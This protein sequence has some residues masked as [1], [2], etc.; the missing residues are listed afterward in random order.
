MAVNLELAHIDTSHLLEVVTGP[1]TGTTPT[2]TTLLVSV[3]VPVF[4]E[5]DVIREFVERVLTIALLLENSYEFEIVLVDDGSTDN[6]LHI[7]ESLAREEPRLKLV[8]LSRNFGQTPA[9]QAGLDYAQGDIIITMDSDLQHFPEEI[10]QFLNKLNEGFDM[11]C[12]WRHERAE[13]AIRR[14]PSRMANKLLRTITGLP[15]HDFGTTFRAYRAEVA[16]ELRLHGE[17]HRFIPALVHDL[18]ARIAELPIQNI[19]RPAGKSKYG[20]GR[21]LGVFLDMFVLHF[22]MRYIRQP[23]RAFGKLGLCAFLCGAA[24]MSYMIVVAYAYDFPMFRERPGWFLL[25]VMLMLSAVQIFIAGI[26]AEM[27]IRIRFDGSGMTTYRVRATR[28]TSRKLP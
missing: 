6:T 7:L 8:Q 10:P 18:G 15:F 3:V 17:F 25:S 24:I 1:P 14:W 20:I 27:L 4:N 13:G 16:K 23:M 28:G 12:G 9:L 22:F 21:T 19:E 26:L 2:A 11:V 5:E